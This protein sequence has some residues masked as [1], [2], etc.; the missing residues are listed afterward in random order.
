MARSVA[1]R[2]RERLRSDSRLTGDSLPVAYEDQSGV[3]ST[4]QGDELAPWVKIVNE[5]GDAVL[6]QGDVA[7]DDPDS[8]NPVKT[9][10]HATTAPRAAV[11]A[12]D[13]RADHSTDLRG[14]QR[15]R[16]SGDAPDN[17]A[18]D[19]PLD[20]ADALQ[21][22]GSAAHDAADTGHPNKTGAHANAAPRGAV[23]AEDDRVDHSA[24]L[25]GRQRSRISGDAPDNTPADVALDTADALQ[26]G[27]SAAHD[28][29]DTGHPNK[30]GGH[31]NASPRGVVDAEDDRT[32]GSTDLRG[33]FRSR[34]SGDRDNDNVAVD[35]PLDSANALFVGGQDA[36]DE[37]DT[38][39]PLLIG[40]HA[41]AET[42]AAVDDDDRVRAYLSQEGRQIV[43][44]DLSIAGENL[45]HDWLRTHL[46]APA[47]EQGSWELSHA[48]D[49]VELVV[50]ASAGRLRQV[51]VSNNNGS[52][53]YLMIFNATSVPG[54]GAG[55]E[56]AI[57]AIGIPAGDSTVFHLPEMGIYFDT[58][59][60]IGISTSITDYTSGTASEHDITAFFK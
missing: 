27:G 3:E 5:A 20:T 54:S 6:V 7:H 16:L 49:A 31:G 37:V 56:P 8:G 18:A 40:G 25:R 10:G 21:V 60:S 36:H 42:P 52:T 33:R 39:Y 53:R 59:I 45:T 32:D 23:D 15:T 1:Q 58:G 4:W 28:A 38:G 35:V 24:D 51:V 48:E 22:G 13:D 26:V 50:K 11:S 19:I 2:R 14:R 17:T 46:A 29:A 57:A 41:Y 34:V 44:Q 43:N 47:V 12:D 55:N 9:G 30:V